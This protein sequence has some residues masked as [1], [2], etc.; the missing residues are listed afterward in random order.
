MVRL[1]KEQ[2]EANMIEFV[3]DI[4]KFLPDE[5][6][7]ITVGINRKWMDGN[8][9]WSVYRTPEQKY[10]NLEFSIK[11]NNRE[12]ALANKKTKKEGKK[13]FF[14]KQ[15]WVSPQYERRL[16][17]L[18]KKQCNILETTGYVITDKIFIHTKHWHFWIHFI[19]VPKE[20][21]NPYEYVLK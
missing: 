21:A 8:S 4:E 16:N 10:E 11:H 15:C 17:Q 6:M 7:D 20:E 5:N 14:N 12:Y 9:E 13:I 3:K 2:K 19:I 18:T 1:T